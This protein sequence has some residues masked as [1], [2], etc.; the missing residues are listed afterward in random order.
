V[1]G[2][3]FRQHQTSGLLSGVLLK[4]VDI[5][6]NREDNEFSSSFTTDCDL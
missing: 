5:D 2:R 4:S 1:S 3:L 6:T